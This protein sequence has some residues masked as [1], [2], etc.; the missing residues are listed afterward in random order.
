M[1]DSQHLDEGDD[2]TEVREQREPRMEDAEWNPPN[3]SNIGRPLST[4][5]RLLRSLKP[6]QVK[7]IYHPDVVCQGRTCTLATMMVRL[8]KTQGWKVK[9]YHEAPHVMVVARE[10][11]GGE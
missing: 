8:R 11:D 9:A 6:G 3:S 10:P 1:P 4:S 7:R 2:M 5:A